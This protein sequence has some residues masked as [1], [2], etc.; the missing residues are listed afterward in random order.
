M[1]FLTTKIPYQQTGFYSK[2]IADY[3]NNEEGIAPFFEHGVN[4]DGLR[5]S[6]AKRAKYSINRK[7]L[8]EAL[9]SKYTSHET[10]EAVLRNISLLEHDTTFTITTAHQ[11]N[12]FTGPLYFLYKIL[13]AIK[14]AEYCKQQF[15]QYDFVPVY[16]MGSEDADLDELGHIYINGE[17]LNWETGQTGAVGRMLA[18][19]PLLKLIERIAGETGVE[20]FGEEIIS[21]VKK[22]YNEGTSIQDATLGFVNSLFGKYGLII[23]I[24]DRPRLKAL[25]QDVFREE[26]LRSPSSKI[27]EE[28][29][30][31]L[32]DAGYP[33]QAYSR[34]I[35][36][37][38]LLDDKR[39]RLEKESGLWKVAGTNIVFTE[40]QLLHELQEHPERFSPNV[41]LRGIFQEMVLPNIAFIGGGGE[42]AYWL[43]TKEIFE[44]YAVPY[45]MLVLRNSFL[46]AGKENTALKEKLGFSADEIFQ[47]L[48]A[49]QNRWIEKNTVNNLS[50]DAALAAAGETY[51]QLLHQAETIDSTLTQHIEALKKNAQKRV[52]ELGKKMLRAEKRNHGA[53]MRQIEKLKQQLFPNDNLQE[54]IDNFIPYYAK[55][56]DSLIE[57]LYENS[58]ALDQE[59][60]VL[61]EI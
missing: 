41:I 54:R 15:P 48:Q 8:T 37:F 56:G 19:K 60:V 34:E 20:P 32:L 61:E 4:P 9:R 31:R 33:A 47:P 27:T 45:P 14:L 11:P 52:S 26:L 5:N 12:I 43:Q 6:I 42:L 3:L 35:N 24:P 58:L 44:H 36:F 39:E 51:G 28:T 57:T 10:Q 22:N 23:L 1:A 55:W 30:K 13:H 29:G 25:A 18:D 17:K 59:F 21:L 49:L 40:E 16:Y 38:Y 46:I 50:V 53:A 2:I 7:A